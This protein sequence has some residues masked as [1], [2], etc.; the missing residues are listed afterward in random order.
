MINIFNVCLFLFLLSSCE[1]KKNDAVTAIRSEKSCSYLHG[2]EQAI[3]L[4]EAN[5]QEKAIEMINDLAKK[6]DMRAKQF[7]DSNPELRNEK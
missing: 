1:N 7:L 6:G 2:Y 3:C 4:L 5:K